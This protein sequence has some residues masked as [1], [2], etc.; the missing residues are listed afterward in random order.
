VRG[1]YGGG[2][3]PIFYF[4]FEVA[5]EGSEKR[6]ALDILKISQ[7]DLQCILCGA[8]SSTWKHLRPLVLNKNSTSY[9]SE[10]YN[11]VPSCGKCNQ[12]KGNKNWEEWMVSDARP[13]PKSK[14]VPD[15]ND[16]IKRLKKYETWQPPA[17]IDIETIVGKDVMSKHWKNCDK[18]QS[19]MRESQLL[20]EKIN[21]EVERKYRKMG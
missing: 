4:R 2:V 9:I 12:S 3:H 17:Q 13:S 21:T 14:N 18:V 8:Q 7:D 10:I 5:Y 6:T 19:V 16:R 11:L 1:N 20:A 15:L